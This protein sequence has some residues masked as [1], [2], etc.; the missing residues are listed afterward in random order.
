GRVELDPACE[1]ATLEARTADAGGPSADAIGEHALTWHEAARDPE[2]VP[3]GRSETA[4]QPH[5]LEGGR[6]VARIRTPDVDARLGSR[7]EI[8]A[9]VPLGSAVDVDTDH[10]DVDVVPRPGV[11][12][13][14]IE[15]AADVNV[16]TRGSEVRVAKAS[17]V[18]VEGASFAW[19][20]QAADVTVRR[21]NGQDERGTAEIGRVTE[22]LTVQDSAADVVVGDAAGN[23]SAVTVDRGDITANVSGAGE[24]SFTARNGL[25]T[26]SIAQS[27]PQSAKVTAKDS[28]GPVDL[29]DLRPDGAGGAG[30]GAG[31]AAAASGE[32]AAGPASTAVVEAAQRAAVLAAYHSGWLSRHDGTGGRTQDEPVTDGFSAAIQAAYTQGWDDR[33]KLTDAEAATALAG[34]GGGAAA[35]AAG[36]AAAPPVA[37]PVAIVVQGTDTTRSDVRRGRDGRG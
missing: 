19:V 15:G 22:R 21:M 37:V 16:V 26:G 12:W 9:R 6:L 29:H 25:V 31:G 35:A 33:H 1:R 34:G 23:W 3:N 27:V 4:V 2:L 30:A 32:A 20:G 5:P 11:S 8:V 28:R 36:A 17:S 18:F 13:D 14:D 24:H 10:A 7:V